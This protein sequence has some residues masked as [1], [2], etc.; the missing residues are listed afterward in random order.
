MLAS[1]ACWLLWRRGPTGGPGAVVHGDDGVPR[2]R[3]RGAPAWRTSRM[4]Y[5][6]SRCPG[7]RRVAAGTAAGGPLR[8]AGALRLFVGAT[9]SGF[10]VRGEEGRHGL[11]ASASRSGVRARRPACGPVSTPPASR[12]GRGREGRGREGRGRGHA[13]CGRGVPACR[14]ATGGVRGPR[15]VV[16]H[17]PDR[18]GP[19][20]RSRAPPSAPRRA[21]PVGG[22]SARPLP[23]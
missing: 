6:V 12:F 10:V 13:S 18:T 14:E 8:G 1:K 22:R 23:R 3:V 11:R 17:G 21:P 15:D 5:V 9:V 4:C 16:H 19:R 7:R 20:V 2:R